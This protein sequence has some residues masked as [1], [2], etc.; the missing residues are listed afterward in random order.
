M[1]PPPAPIYLRAT[2]QPQE[3][4]QIKLR[5]PVY[6]LLVIHTSVVHMP[7]AFVIPFADH[8]D[9]LVCVRVNNIRWGGLIC[10]PSTYF[11]SSW[12]GPLRGHQQF[13]GLNENS[14][15]SCVVCNVNDQIDGHRSCYLLPCSLLGHVRVCNFGLTETRTI[16]GLLRHV[17]LLRHT[18][19]LL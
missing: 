2:P 15:T 19:E 3:F 7:P 5:S 10:R 9:L 4:Y 12:M 16:S 6:N 11:H 13:L 14:Q 8:T 17:Y 18:K 1:L